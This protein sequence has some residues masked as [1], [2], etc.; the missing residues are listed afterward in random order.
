MQKIPMTQNGLNMLQRKLYLLKTKERPRIINEIKKA[1]EYGDL[2]ENTEYHAAKEEQYLIELK[3]KEIEHKL[4]YAEVIEINKLLNS[5]KIIF[6]ST[7][8]LLNLK[9]KNIVKYK[10]VGEDEAN[11]KN[12]KISINSPIARA[13]I[14]KLENDI[15]KINVPSGIIEYKITKVI[16]I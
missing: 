7:V 10:I 6:S 14:G 1:R 8:E 5:G 2:K 13:L 9:N 3:I 12:N 4:S 15:I 11:I 16:Y